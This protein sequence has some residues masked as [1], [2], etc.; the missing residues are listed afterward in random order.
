MPELLILIKGMVAAFRSV[1]FTLCLLIFILYVFGIVFTQVTAGAL[2]PFSSVGESMHTLL[3]QGT[4]LDDLSSLYNEIR[5]SS[6]LF[7]M[8]FYMYVLLSALTVMN[9]LIGVLCE[10]VSAVASTEREELTVNHVRQQMRYIMEEQSIDKDGDGEISKEEF[11][12]IIENGQAIKVLFDIGVDPMGLMDLV[13]FIF[14]DETDED[15]HVCPK[16][17]TFVEFMELVLSLRGS[18]NATVKD[19]VD[20]RK[21]VHKE[22][23]LTITRLA[24]LEQRLGPSLARSATWSTTTN[25]PTIKARPFYSMVD[26]QNGPASGSFLPT[27]GATPT[28][29][30]PS[31]PQP[32]KQPGIQ[33]PSLPMPDLPGAV[34]DNF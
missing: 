26:G 4:F 1:F 12:Q 14:E 17:L 33:V 27:A 13:D 23:M 11:L 19:V 10:V 21:F 30:H 32:L 3:V 5:E 7:L 24:K 25:N 8:L 20:L 6:V 34:A 15:G 28:G 18:N 16:N 22:T 29:G 31:V 2:E 9:M